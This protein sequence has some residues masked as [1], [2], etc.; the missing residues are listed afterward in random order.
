[1]LW[2]DFVTKVNELLNIVIDPTQR[3]SADKHLN[4]LYE[5][6]RQEGYLCK[7]IHQQESYD[8]DKAYNKLIAGKHKITWLRIGSVAA[9]VLLITGIWG[10][11]KL[12]KD[13]EKLEVPTQIT[14]GIHRAFLRTDDG[15]EILLSQEKNTIT[16]KAG[17]K[18][19]TDSTGLHYNSEVGTEMIFREHIN[20][21]IVPRVS[22][23]MIT[24]SDGTK[25]WIN[26]ES[27]LKYPTTFDDKNRKVEIKGEAYFEV[28]KC[29]EGRSFIVQT[30]Y[31]SITVLGTEFAVRSY[32]DK[33]EWITTL[34]NGEVKC[35]LNSGEE[36]LLNPNDQLIVTND[37]SPLLREVNPIYWTGWREGV[38]IFQ[39][40]RLED[41]MEQLSRWYDVYI[42]YGNDTV[43]NLHFSGDL[44]RYESIETFIE[45]FERSK[46]VKIE[47][48]GNVLVI[49]R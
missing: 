43:K 26:S 18:V 1:M 6:T 37:K 17:V 21:L 22:E 16:D 20:T 14:Y 29:K 5:S 47:K 44:S 23:F 38:F 46:A 36:F 31:G 45:L 33:N 19:H 48:N 30:A 42:F 13:Y 25:V 7:K 3:K 27:E 8:H 2:N 35:T 32:E 12:S 41:I 15:R 49:N 40:E 10:I 4:I 34:V 11:L 28:A 24:L 9:G 39:E